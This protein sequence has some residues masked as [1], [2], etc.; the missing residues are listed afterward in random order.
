MIISL[1][2]LAYDLSDNNGKKGDNFLKG[3]QN[4]TAHYPFMTV[5]GSRDN[6]NGVNYADFRFRMP[7]YSTSQNKYYSFNVDRVHFIFFDLGYYSNNTV[8]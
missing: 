8:V 7:Q 2:N 4:L 5:D 6:L 1:G 3:I